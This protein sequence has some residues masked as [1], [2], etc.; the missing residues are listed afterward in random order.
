MKVGSSS[1]DDQE[2]EWLTHMASGNNLRLKIK[3]KTMRQIPKSSI[4]VRNW[5]KWLSKNS[6]KKGKMMW[7]SKANGF[8]LNR[9]QI[10]VWKYQQGCKWMLSSPLAS[11]YMGKGELE[12]HNQRPPQTT[13]LSTDNARLWN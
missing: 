1:W 10:L 12:V 8:W 4:N 9:R 7:A 6:H 13:V 5:H 3:R 2:N 11:L